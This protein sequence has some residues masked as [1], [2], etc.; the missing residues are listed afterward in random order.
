MIV[1]ASSLSA[2]NV[3]IH[4]TF[5]DTLTLEDPMIDRIASRVP[6]STTSNKYP[7]G[8]MTSTMRQWL[9]DREITGRGSR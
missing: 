6:S 5:Q 4:K 3:Q 1:N 8:W 7:I 9:G 2:L